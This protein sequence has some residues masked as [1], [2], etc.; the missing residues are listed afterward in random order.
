MARVYV[1]DEEGDETRFVQIFRQLSANGV[2]FPE[3]DY[4]FFKKEDEDKFKKNYEK[5]V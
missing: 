2:T 1:K 5:W 4:N 3:K